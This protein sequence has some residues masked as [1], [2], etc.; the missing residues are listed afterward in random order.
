MRIP[1]LLLIFVVVVF[2]WSVHFP[3]PLTF[4][5]LPNTDDSLAV[6]SSTTVDEHHDPEVGEDDKSIK[7][8][9]SRPEHPAG[10]VRDVERMEKH[11]DQPGMRSVSH[12]GHGT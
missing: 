1:A 6:R 3:L 5:L 4:Q 7:T 8:E 10:A 11:L 12:T 2:F 9:R